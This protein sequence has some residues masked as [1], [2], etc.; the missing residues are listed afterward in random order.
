MSAKQRST[1]RRKERR[2]GDEGAIRYR[3]LS[4]DDDVM[5]WLASFLRLEASGWKGREGTAM[6]VNASARA[7]LVA[8]CQAAHARGQLHMLAMELDGHP[9]AMKCNFISGPHAFT[10][11]IAYEE[12]HARHSP[13]LLIEL[14]QMRCIRE[15]FPLL[16]AI[17]SCTV[18]DNTMFPHLWPGR[19]EL[20]DYAILHNNVLNRL[21][22]HQ[23][24]RMQRILKH[25]R[26]P[27]A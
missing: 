21:M 4:T 16:Q 17:D 19:C 11:K 15:M 12:A 25:H 3:T 14:Y 13:G 18:A 27:V 23:G 10:F 2:L 20:G 26:A 6:A 8:A 22:L 24:E 5:D 1:L 7:F 9:V